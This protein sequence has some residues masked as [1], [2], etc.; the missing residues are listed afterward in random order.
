MDGRILEVS[1]H[2]LHVRCNNN[3][4]IVYLQEESYIKQGNKQSSR[5]RNYTKPLYLL[6]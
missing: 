2:D 1:E 3:G 5:T 6:C 4:L